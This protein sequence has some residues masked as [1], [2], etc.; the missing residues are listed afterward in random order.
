MKYVVLV[1]NLCICLSYPVNF[2]IY[3]GMSR[4]FRETFKELFIQRVTSAGNNNNANANANGKR[5]SVGGNGNGA[6]AAKAENV[7]LNIPTVAVNGKAG[8]KEVNC[9]Y[10][11]SPKNM[12][13]PQF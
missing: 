1:I 5:K 10:I 12:E 6:A 11:Q 2:G 3:C 7:A 4:Q 9:A 8:Y 13:L